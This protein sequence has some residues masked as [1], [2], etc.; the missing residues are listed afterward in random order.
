M[1]G[2][3]RAD[4]RAIQQAGRPALPYLLFYVDCVPC[5]FLC[6]LCCLIVRCRSYVFCVILCVSLVCSGRPCRTCASRRCRRSPWRRAC[7]R[8]GAQTPPVLAKLLCMC[9]FGLIV[10]YWFLRFIVWLL[11][12]CCFV[13]LRCSQS[14]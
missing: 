3:S 6:V 10:C 12:C 7:P 1:R 4:A 9:L 14:A 8:G 5:V 13:C 2:A 11:M